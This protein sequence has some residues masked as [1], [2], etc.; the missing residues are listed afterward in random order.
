MK[1]IITSI[2][3]AS[4]LAGALYA[5]DM[6]SGF[7]P[8]ENDDTPD[9]LLDNHIQDSKVLQKLAISSINNSTLRALYPIEN[10]DTPDYLFDNTISEKPTTMHAMKRSLSSD[11][12]CYI[13][14]TEDSDEVTY[15]SGC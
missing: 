11:T 3:G 5:Q 1:R 15:N 12:L 6:T 7:Y 10:D 14:P 8:A 9:Y 13:Y 2:L 4:L